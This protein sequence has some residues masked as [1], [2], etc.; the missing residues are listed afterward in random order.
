VSGRG[1]SAHGGTIVMALVARAS[2][3]HGMVTTRADATP[4][5]CLRVEGRPEP[6]SPLEAVK[7]SSLESSIM[8][9]NGDA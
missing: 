9:C 7:N 5:P 2:S 3:S 6:S 8:A 1:A 4:V